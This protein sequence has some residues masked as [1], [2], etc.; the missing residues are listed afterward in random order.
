MPWIQDVSNVS[1]K[2][3]NSFVNDDY[4]TRFHGVGHFVPD[5]T[6]L[7]VTQGFFG[8]ATINFPDAA[9]SRATST[10]FVPQ[11]WNHGT[12]SAVLYVGNNTGTAGNVHWKL[13]ANVFPVNSA[14]PAETTMYDLATAMPAVS[15]MTKLESTATLAVTGDN[16]VSVFRVVRVGDAGDDTFANV[17]SF[18]GMKIIY[19][20]SRR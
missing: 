13:V 19:T 5:G 9:V 4:Y 14:L 10:F 16:E 8:M 20:P 12:L 6:S 18:I 2:S 17:A 11:M 15:I 3:I 1:D 7:A